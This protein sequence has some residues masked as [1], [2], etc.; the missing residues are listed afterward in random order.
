MAPLIFEACSHIG[1]IDDVLDII[2]SVLNEKELA[3][4]DEGDKGVV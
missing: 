3:I 2:K 1:R 4:K